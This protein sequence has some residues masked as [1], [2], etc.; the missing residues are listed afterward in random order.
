MRIVRGGVVDR[1]VLDWILLNVR[2]PQEREGDLDAQMGACRVGEQRV[3]QLVAKYGDGEAGGVGRGA[4]RL[5]GA[6]GAG[7]A[8]EDA[9]GRSSTQKTGWTTTA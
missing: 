3:L 5:L 2:T 6:A 4:A 8:A 7:G 1:E 9:G